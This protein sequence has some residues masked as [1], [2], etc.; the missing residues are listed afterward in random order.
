MTRV[1]AILSVLSAAVFGYLGA[2]Q[3]TSMVLRQQ[4]SG[5]HWPHDE[6]RV[7]TGG[8]V[9]GR[10]FVTYGGRSEWSGF[11]GGGPGGGK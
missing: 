10:G 4:P 8:Y 5:L 11:R 6:G 2:R 3:Q 1:L 7:H 9:Y